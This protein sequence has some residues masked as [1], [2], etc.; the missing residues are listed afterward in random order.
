MQ[1]RLYWAGVIAFGVLWLG[2][3]CGNAYRAGVRCPH[4]KRSAKEKEAW[5][6]QKSVVRTRSTFATTLQHFALAD[7]TLTDLVP[8]SLRVRRMPGFRDSAGLRM[9]PLQWY[10]RR[11]IIDG[12][13]EAHHNLPRLLGLRALAEN[14]SEADTLYAIHTVHH[15]P[16]YEETMGLRKLRMFAY[17]SALVLPGLGL[18][19]AL[20]LWVIYVIH[21]RKE[22]GR[23]VPVAGSMWLWIYLLMGAGIWGTVVVMGWGLY[24]VVMW[25]VGWV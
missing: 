23:R 17:M 10:F 6:V 20:V 12:Q 4:F 19:I 22:Y 5:R 7:T 18:G 11:P 16:I 24:K 1:N 13:Q 14:F 21:Y 3:G 25:L 8:F 2:G 9:F 15:V